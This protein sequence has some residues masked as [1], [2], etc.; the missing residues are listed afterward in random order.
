MNVREDLL[1]DMVA[2]L[3]KDDARIKQLEAEIAALQV[4]A[5]RYRWIRDQNNREEGARLLTNKMNAD[6]AIDTARG[7]A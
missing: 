1:T 7:A 4:D 5:E 3:Y 6:A 2:T